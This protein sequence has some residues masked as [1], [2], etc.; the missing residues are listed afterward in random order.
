MKSITEPRRK[1]S[2]QTTTLI[3]LR[4]VM[5]LTIYYSYF[6]FMKTMSFRKWIWNMFNHILRN[7]GTNKA[8]P[9]A[10]LS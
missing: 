6:G 9:W 5:Q 2:V 3:S 1:H 7:A 10:Q 4:A 8:N